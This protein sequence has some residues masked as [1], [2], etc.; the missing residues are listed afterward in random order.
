[1]QFNEQQLKII[2]TPGGRIAV[3]A[4][5]GSGKTTTTI[6]LIE[7]LHLKDG[8][9]LEKMFIST[10]TNKAGK[11]I[12]TRLQKRFNLDTEHINKLWVGTFHSLGH[13]YL[14]QIKKLNLN[15][16][17]PV[18]GSYYLKNIYKAVLQTEGEDENVVTFKDISENIEM[19]RNQNCSW[20]KAS[21][22][23]DICRKVHDQYQKEKKEQDLVDFTDI[24]E[25]FVS[26]L[27]KDVIFTNK[28]SWVFV[29]EVQDNNFSQNVLTDLLTTESVVRVGDLKQCWHKD[30]SIP[31][32]L[33]D[34][35]IV[36]KKAIDVLVG[37]RVKS[38]E[39]HN[40]TCFHCVSRKEIFDVSGFVKITTISGRTLHVS[41]DHLVYNDVQRKLKPFV[42][43]MYDRFYG[44]RI[45]TSIG[46]L[47]QRARAEHSNRL[48]LLKEC[49]TKEES[50]MY[51]KIYSLEYQIP[52]IVFNWRPGCLL[53]ETRKVIF[54]KFGKNKNNLNRIFKDFNLD[55]AFPHYMS[56]QSNSLSYRH[57]LIRIKLI[58]L[59]EKR[60]VGRNRKF[61]VEIGCRANDVLKQIL[62]NEGYLLRKYFSKYE[63]AFKWSSGIEKT[64][65]ENGYSHV[66]VES[67][68][69][70]RKNFILKKAKSLLRG[71]LIL[72]NGENQT[73]YEEIKEIQF[74][75]EDTQIVSLDVPHTGIITNESGIVSHN[76]IY[77][78][79]GA[80]PQLFKDNIKIANHTYYLSYN[81]RSTQQIIGFANAMLKQIP[82]FHGQE[83][84][85]L[86]INGFKPTFIICD[87]IALR[88][89][90][91]IRHDISTG[92]P[93]GEIAVLGRSVKPVSIQRLQVLLRR[94]RIPYTV[95]GGSDKLNAPFIQNF[96][97][98]LKSLANP[99]KVSLVNALSILP[100][101][102]PKT[103]FKLAESVVASGMSFAPLK[104]A[105]GRFAQ[106]KA[107]QGYLNLK[108]LHD[109]DTM[110]ELLLRS[111]DFYH[112]HYLVPYYG[113]KDPTEPSN[114]K[115]IIFEVLFNYLMGY[116][117]LADG[118]D[119]LYVNEDDAD[120]GENKIV[121]STVHQCV[122][123][124]TLLETDKG[125]QE[126]SDIPETG[127]IG[128]PSG[129]KMYKGKFTKS[130][131]DIFKIQ[132]KKGYTLNA[133]PEHGVSVW[134]G[135]SFARK[136]ADELKIKDIIR[137][138]LG[139][140]IPIQDYFSL[141]KETP[142]DVREVVYKLPTKLGEDIGELLGLIVGDGTIY[143]RGLRI[144]K[145]QI[146]VI[147]KP[148]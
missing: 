100:S 121:I 147:R 33:D 111:F 81:Y 127:N 148:L 141:H 6:K 68:Y 143:Y 56:L 18:E 124:E 21:E 48:W 103:A 23:P 39:G 102:G 88:I 96:L 106:T 92:I 42:Y 66:F 133:S 12:K 61:E 64:L 63:E 104:T 144:S 20:D 114:K 140:T 86:P 139:E 4:G 123:R 70:D 110:K 60:K 10:F 32:Q 11:D 57:E 50:L 37:D 28:F 119:S 97:S 44:Y 126:I 26:Q 120:D 118:I 132:T 8:I 138:K 7:K 91:A 62:V 115:T 51:E 59:S 82:A 78:W 129:P 136:R 112:D 85:H 80:T 46:V 16:I 93:F 71:S 38:L 72:V 108:Y 87:D 83:L 31:V 49:E 25:I 95:R 146:E 105:S 34:G 9:A 58:R 1:M 75:D 67:I 27:K 109:N 15:I 101:V 22:Y 89:Y 130:G 79:R 24:L 52:E 128:T 36:N 116:K 134:D 142:K 5:A 84:K 54:D 30:E 47:G 74:I 77:K 45:G 107:F 131:G 43:L 29:D 73:F 41:K 94:D 13:R 19:K 117:N 53:D 14:T 90:K 98:V 137:L 99:T 35:H 3:I 113:K 40:V 76:S 65:G 145:D 2:N 69:L 125:L 122:T 17:L 55:Y 135:I